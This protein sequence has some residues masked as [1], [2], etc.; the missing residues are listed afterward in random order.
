MYTLSGHKNTVSSIKCFLNNKDNN[1]YLISADRNHVVIIWEVNNNF[2][3]KYK[4]E[5]KYDN[6]I[7]SCLLVFPFNKTENFI[8]TSTY[9]IDSF[10]K[11]F[12]F[13]TGKFIR[14]LEKIKNNQTCYLIEWINNKNDKYYIIQLSLGQI[15]INNLF[16]DEQYCNLKIKPEK[17]LYSGFIYNNYLYFSSFD[18]YIRILNLFEKTI[19]KV[20]QFPNCSFCHIIQWNYKYIIMADFYKKT[21]KIMDLDN[22]KYISNY[23][24]QH[25]N[26]VKC[27]KK[28]YHPLYGESL[29]SSGWDKTIKLWII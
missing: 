24:G 23:S 29:L 8:I 27:V 3:R 13:E 2:N 19:F 15:L 5:T 10:T 1:Q 14:Y 17:D 28:I 25:N 22:N 21:I 26:V 12:S 16:E 7:Y 6:D 18:G 4:I 11:I 20:I 9:D